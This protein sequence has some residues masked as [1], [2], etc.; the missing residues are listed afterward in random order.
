MVEVAKLLEPVSKLR[1]RR[2]GPLVLELD[3]TEGI[4]DESP[5]DPLGQ[6]LA[7][8]RQRLFD[9][10]EGIRRGARDP[11]VKALIAKIGSAPISFGKLQELR[12]AVGVF[13]ASGKPALAWSESFGDF[14]PGTASYYLA[15]A[16]S[17]I[18]LVPSGAVG[19]TGL[20][21]TNRFL[22]D[23]V[24]K[25]G[26]DYEIG[27]RHEYKNA[28]NMLT[29]R[30]F[31]GPHR[32]AT[33]RIVASLTEQVVEGISEGRGLSAQDVRSL[34]DRGPFISH[35]AL[36]A[37]LVDRLGYRDEIYGELLGRF[38][39]PESE[40]EGAR[41]QFVSRYQRAQTL[42]SRVPAV[43]RGEYVA[44]VSGIGQIIPGRSRRSPLGGSSAMGSDTVAAAFRAA[45]ADPKARAVVFRVDSGGG[46]Y[47]ASD[48][49]RREVKL[50]SEAG[51]PV[52]VSMG[53]VA[54][55]GGYFIA[56]G[57]DSI[58]AKPGTLTGSI[59]VFIVK[60]VLSE[61]MGKLGISSDSIDA[62]SHATM[63]ST[64]RKFSESEWE[65]VNAMLDHVYDDFTAKVAE[66][67]GMT[68]E[69]VHEVARGRVWTGA[70]AHTHGLVDELGGVETAA[71][72]ARK[73]AGL[74]SMT[75]LRPFPQPNPLERLV[76]P[77]SSEDKTA[78][79][80]RVSS[81]GPLAELSARIG[82]PAAG[83]LVMPGT[84]EIR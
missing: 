20:S 24:E 7:M 4:S 60:A 58:V 37:G 72:I 61:L 27:A 10:L 48:V 76:P 67:R 9:I 1:Q 12:T 6:L 35:E 16:F 71:G 73:R 54:A 8:R 49:I 74:P 2:A 81:W 33:E 69:Q 17:E 23:A 3:L 44:L 50:T 79:R 80:L 82:L 41:L 22:R 28:V 45:R 26:V 11:R 36:E 32:E 14:G 34:I 59:G 39:G 55:S 5:G 29:E 38:R 68:R 57:A 47:T 25:L 64:D 13:R 53:D 18:A 19:L 70:D 42:A 46:S 84:W 66:A 77:E 40:H 51:K 30:D 65:R 31:T 75:A 52:V 83:P 78:A 43:Q 63:Y 56:L 21:V 15:T 62:G